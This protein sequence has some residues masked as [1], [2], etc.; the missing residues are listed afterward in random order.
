MNPVEVGAR[1]SQAARAGA[2]RQQQAFAGEPASLFEN[3]FVG[4]GIDRGD[5][6]FEDQLDGVVRIPLRRMH[7]D[8][9]AFTAVQVLL[10]QRRADVR[11][12]RFGADDHDSSLIAVLAESRRGRRARESS[13][14]D[15]ARAL[16]HGSFLPLLCRSYGQAAVASRARFRLAGHSRTVR[17]PFA[18]RSRAV[19]GPFARHPHARH[20]AHTA[21]SQP[22]LSQRADTRS[23]E[24]RTTH[25]HRRRRA[26]HPRSP[27]HQ[28]PLRRFRRARCRQRCAGHLRGPRRGT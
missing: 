22:S 9:V 5:D 15:D 28:P 26:Q 7:E 16:R 14:D 21:A 18:G 10:R 23:H 27:H 12:V 8:L 20:R 6:R 19:R 1:H 4:A 25:S 11:I 2:G 13:S 17:G 24:R 3:D